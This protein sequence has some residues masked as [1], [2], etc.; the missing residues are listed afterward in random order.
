MLNTPNRLAYLLIFL[1][2]VGFA[3]CKDKKVTSRRPAAQKPKPV[4]VELPADLQ[5]EEYKVE[6]E[7]Y[8]YDPKGRRD[9]FVSLV[10]TAERKPRKEKA[11]SPIERFDVEEIKLIA[12]VWDSQQYFAMITLPNN[13]SYT[14]K[15]GM[16]LGLYGGKVQEITADTMRIRELVRD[17]KGRL[18]TK[19]TILRLRK[20]EGE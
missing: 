14:I 15:K 17:Y 4:T 11:A 5:K 13:K 2:I 19:D 6:K 18:K 8:T 7:V 10:M 9:P 20:E 16:I 12:I 3:G 1:L